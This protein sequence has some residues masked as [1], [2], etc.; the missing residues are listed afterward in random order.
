MQRVGYGS[1]QIPDFGGPMVVDIGGQ[2]V[3]IVVDLEVGRPGA[4][5]GRL[6]NQA[7]GKLPLHVECELAILGCTWLGSTK[8]TFC[9]SAVPRPSEL[10]VG[11]QCRA[12][13]DC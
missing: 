11:S 12:D 7:A 2:N 13:M 5:I 6:H 9:P 10:P 8:E 1:G 4:D 3:D